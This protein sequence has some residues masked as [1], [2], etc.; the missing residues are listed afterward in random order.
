[1][2][3]IVSLNIVYWHNY[4]KLKK[5]SVDMCTLYD[6]RYIMHN[7]EINGHGINSSRLIMKEIN[8]KIDPSNELSE[9]DFQERRLKK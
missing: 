2:T 4:V 6:Y 8:H 9:I 3:W 1:M 5:K 7:P